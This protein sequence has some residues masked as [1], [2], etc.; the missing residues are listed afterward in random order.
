MFLI[1]ENMNERMINMELNLNCFDDIASLKDIHKCYL[2]LNKKDK[3]IFHNHNRLFNKNLD[4]IINHKYYSKEKVLK[5]TYHS[6]V[7]YDMLDNRR[8]LT[9]DEKK[10]I[11]IKSKKYADSF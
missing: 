10:S 6:Q 2:K 11:Y 7:C 8:K 3:R 4:Y 5:A 1:S 9:P